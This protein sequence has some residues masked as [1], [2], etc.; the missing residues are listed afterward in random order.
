[1]PALSNIQTAR[2]SQA[3]SHE[4]CDILYKLYNIPSSKP[5]FSLLL[6]LQLQIYSP[7]INAKL[8]LFL[9]Y[10]NI[11]HITAFRVISNN[12]G[13]ITADTIGC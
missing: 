11:L 2:A 9:L 13:K 3:T 6:I 1:M 4:D 7:N 8:L 5:A 10:F 12:K